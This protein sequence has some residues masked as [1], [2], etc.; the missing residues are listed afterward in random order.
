MNLIG[1]LKNKG[2]A[3][4]PMEKEGDLTAKDIMDKI[5]N[6]Y[7]KLEKCNSETRDFAEG[8]FLEL[9][10]H[11][12]KSMCSRH[13]TETQKLLMALIYLESKPGPEEEDPL[14]NGFSYEDLSLMFDVSKA[15]VHQAIRQKEEEAKKLL[16]D[17]QLREKAKEIALEQLIEEEKRKLKKKQPKK[18]ANNRTNA[19]N[20][21]REAI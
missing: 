11:Y 21:E 19:H 15:T 3:L 16:V 1:V 4:P 10:Y 5:R 9:L 13:M 14:W 6:F 8:Y 7:N 2:V 18:Q 17:V 12:P 20:T